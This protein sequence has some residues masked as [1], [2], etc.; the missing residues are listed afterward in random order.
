MF[1]LTSSPLENLNLK[2]GFHS[3]KTGAFN[4]FEGLVRNHNDGK[5]VSALEYEADETLCQKEAEKIF[6]EA[7]KKF[8]IISLKCVHRIGKLSVGEM[9][10]WIGVSA[11]HR[12]DSF[13]ACRYLID[14]IKDRLP[15]WKK[16]HFADGHSNWVNGMA[17]AAELK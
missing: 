13:K 17:Q 11:S 6:K 16:E 2:E 8:N 12:D 1:Y 3:K 5:M 10:V 9:A 15:I 4:S 7:K 14:E